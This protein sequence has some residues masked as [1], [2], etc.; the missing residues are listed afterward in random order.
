MSMT[1]ISI[2]NIKDNLIR[3][4]IIF[5]ISICE[6]VLRVFESSYFPMLTQNSPLARMLLTWLNNDHVIFEISIVIKS[7]KKKLIVF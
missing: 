4:I 2:N 7:R 5:I 6:F 3:K 1:Y